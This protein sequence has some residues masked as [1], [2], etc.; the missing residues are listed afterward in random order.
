MLLVF[1]A[2]LKEGPPLVAAVDAGRGEAAENDDCAMENGVEL[3]EELWDG[4]VAFLFEKWPPSDSSGVGS[5]CLLELP[6]SD[7]PAD[8]IGF[9]VGDRPELPVVAL[10]KVL[11]SLSTLLFDAVEDRFSAEGADV[12]LFVACCSS[13][14]SRCTFLPL[15]ERH[16]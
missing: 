6:L 15:F 1:G 9:L 2:A 7:T 8:L 13:A 12:A 10:F 3:K 5:C 16:S 14:W 4:M 11:L